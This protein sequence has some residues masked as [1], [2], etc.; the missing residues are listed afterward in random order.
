MEKHHFEGLKD[1]EISESRSLHGS[2]VLTPPAKTPIYRELLNKFADPLIVILIVA[3]FL[4]VG[5]A[6]YEIYHK[7][8][9]TAAY[10][11]PVGIFISIILAVG[12]GFCFE[13]NAKRKFEILNKTNDEQ[14]VKVIR[15]A[16][17][18]EVSRQEIV[19]GEVVIL[20]TGDEIPADG[21]LLE[22]ISLN[23]NESSLTGEPM[24]HKSLIPSADDREATYPSNMVYRGSTVIEGHGL[25]RVTK[26]GDATEYGKVY[27]GAQIENNVKTPLNIQLDKLSKQITIAS[28]VIAGLIIF[29]RIYIFLSE[30]EAV[31][32]LGM[33]RCILNSVMM[34]VTVIVVAVPEGLPMSVTLS[35]A[36]SMRN[37]LLSNNL[38][39]KMHACETM[40]AATVICTDKT[41]TLTQN[42]MTV[43]QT[44]FCCLGTNQSLSDDSESKK[45]IENISVNSTAYIDRSS[46]KFKPIGNP[47]EAAL[48]MWLLKKNIDYE[49]VRGSSEIIYQ[50]T[51]TTEKKYMAT[52]VRSSELGQKILYV[53]GA[54]EIVMKH[55]SAINVCG[56]ECLQLSDYKNDIEA[57]LLEC[58]NR[59]M[60]TLGFA[61]KIVTDEN[62]CFD[63]NG[64]LLLNNL[65]FSGI[66]SISD[67]IR[68]EVPEAIRECIDAGIKIKIVT[69][70]TPATAKEVGR[71]IGL[72]QPMDCDASMISGAELSALSDDE[73]LARLDDLKIVSRAR[74]MDKERLVRMLQKHGEVVAVTGDGTNDAPALNAAQIGLSMGDGTAVAKEASAITIIDNSFKSICNAVLWGRSLY[75]NIQR[76]ILFQMTINV[77]ACLIVLIGS[78]CDYESPLTV[79]QM[80]WVNLIMDTFA[81]IALASLPPHHDV[82]KEKPRKTSDNIVSKKMVS[83]IIS[84]GLMFVAILLCLLNLLDNY[85]VE[86]LSDVLSGKIQK[87]SGGLTDYELSLFFTIFVMMQFWN[88]FNAKAYKSKR[89]AINSMNK[90]RGFVSIA[91]MI[92]LVQAIII[93]FGG[94]MFS[95]TPIRLWDWII[96][97]VATSVVFIVGEICRLVSK[98][99]KKQHIIK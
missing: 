56:N 95:V 73:L 2:N 38:V 27:K 99:Y 25:M 22:A 86:S 9:T 68:E 1:E 78:F 28:Y 51:F 94:K 39:R 35:L 63:S 7:T 85:S 92:L 6:A 67:P 50:S 53:K 58:Q 19:V 59:A 10:L 71:Q 12:V 5:V 23:V 44:N 3:M 93:N 70:D 80:L 45:I 89:S 79:T 87:D 21:E 36:L 64:N 84:V 16:K 98:M 91:I 18:T 75:L 14:G 52:V 41:G 30:T 49:S 61:Y 4:S 81:A 43:A 11:E 31:T 48:L 57:S 72:W 15:N 82:M 37:M 90:S 76:F 74:P 17:V 62:E 8:A 54:P 24:A 46:A 20:D 26:V 60:R 69:G 88:M 47:T 32:M 13:M 40:G 66:V 33:T 55:C 77:T 29:G 96:I 65:I 34:A 83:I 42:Q 97:I